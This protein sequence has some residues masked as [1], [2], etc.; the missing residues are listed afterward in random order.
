MTDSNSKFAAIIQDVFTHWTGL[1][2]EH[3]LEAVDS[4]IY[5]SPI[6]PSIL[7]TT[8]VA[9]LE[10]GIMMSRVS[11]GRSGLEECII[12]LRTILGSPDNKHL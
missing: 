2:E 5:S 3:L 4:H 7:A 10:G 11:K 6:P 12:A 8:I 9:T 1:L